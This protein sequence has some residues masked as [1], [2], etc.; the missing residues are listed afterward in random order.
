MDLR[1]RPLVCASN[2]AVVPMSIADDEGGGVSSKND[3]SQSFTKRTGRKRRTTKKDTIKKREAD[4]GPK[5]VAVDEYWENEDD[6]FLGARWFLDDKNSEE[7]MMNQDFFVD[8][9]WDMDQDGLGYF[10]NDPQEDWRDDADFLMD[11][12]SRNGSWY[13]F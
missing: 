7:L 4:A 2:R 12:F 11:F 3:S 6:D 5:R 1:L 9:D 13:M 10:L 8:D